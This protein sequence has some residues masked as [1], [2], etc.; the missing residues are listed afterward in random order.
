MLEKNMC[1]YGTVYVLNQHQ[2]TCK[3]RKL[4]NLKI[5]RY[6]RRINTTITSPCKMILVNHFEIFTLKTPIE[7][8]KS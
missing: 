4:P 2:E 3:T 6:L 1:Q 5:S 7:H 8:R